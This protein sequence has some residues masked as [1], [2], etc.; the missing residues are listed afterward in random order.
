[1]AGSRDAVQ[2]FPYMSQPGF[3][4]AAPVTP[5]VVMWFKVY[6]VAMALLYLLTIGLSAIFF[7]MDPEDLEMS[8]IE[9][10]V[11]GTML[12]GLGFVLLLM[13]IAGLVLPRR[14]WVWVYDVVLIGLGMTSCLTLPFCIPLLIFWLKPEV[15]V[16]YGRT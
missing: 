15:K 11:M 14:P 8:R 6:C 12:A 1:M 16:L 13:F 4:A 3:P 9:A 10:M 2:Y 7:L 5:P